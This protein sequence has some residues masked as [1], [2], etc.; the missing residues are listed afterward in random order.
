MIITKLP[1]VGKNLTLAETKTAKSEQMLERIY[2]K[3]KVKKKLKIPKAK[4]TLLS[5]HYLSERIKLLNA[6]GYGKTKW[7]EFAEEMNKLG[8]K[9]Y[10]YEARQTFSKYI[11]VRNQSKE[12]L[13]RFSNHRPNRHREIQ[14]DCDF[15]V[16]V[17]N[18]GVKTT[19]DAINFVKNVFDLNHTGTVTL[20]K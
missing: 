1:T 12:V 15:F 18:L 8:L 19:Q 17:T 6:K 16:G 5:S 9:C 4:D 14:G 11:T 10:L 20:S 3:K 13:I 2:G 7:I